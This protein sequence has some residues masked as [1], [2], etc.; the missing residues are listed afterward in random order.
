MHRQ[1]VAK[2]KV[3]V[4]LLVS[5]SIARGSLSNECAWLMLRCPPP[6]LV[7]CKTFTPKYSISRDYQVGCRHRCKHENNNMDTWHR[8]NVYARLIGILVQHDPPLSTPNEYL[9]KSKINKQEL[10]LARQDK[11]IKWLRNSRKLYF[12]A[13]CMKSVQIC[14]HKRHWIHAAFIVL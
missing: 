9:S 12:L 10:V 6:H 3:V 7:L 5:S 4:D 2:L 14:S 8:V 1:S 13:L 11:D